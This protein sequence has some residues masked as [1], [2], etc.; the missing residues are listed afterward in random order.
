MK[1]EG[2]PEYVACTMTCACGAT[3]QTRS[4]KSQLR[5]GICA[6]CHPFFT[7]TQK[8]VDTAG[9]V[10]KFRRRFTDNPAAAPK[11]KAKKRA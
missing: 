11:A 10:E 9:R 2:H 7:G 5:L 1:A 3:Y 6:S 8:F 4:T